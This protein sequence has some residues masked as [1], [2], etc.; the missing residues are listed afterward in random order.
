MSD[1]CKKIAKRVVDLRPTFSS[2]DCFV[3]MQRPSLL[4]RGFAI[5]MPPGACYVWKFMFPLFEDF[6]FVHLTF[7]YRVYDGYLSTRG[8]SDSD[9]AR[10]VADQV[11]IN[12]DFSDQEDVLDLIKFVQDERVAVQARAEASQVIRRYISSEDEQLI[13]KANVNMSRLG[14]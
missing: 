5:D 1:R 10:R 12:N 4:L 7:G 13:A 3:F 14:L 6:E 2:W 8:L 11:D 9:I